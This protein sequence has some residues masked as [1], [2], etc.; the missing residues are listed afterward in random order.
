[1]NI[2]NTRSST[3]SGTVNVNANNKKYVLARSN[4]FYYLKFVNYNAE[5]F[6]TA[7][8]L[9][10]KPTVVFYTKNSA[11]KVI[12]D[13]SLANDT[14]KAY[15]GSFFA[16]FSVGAGFTLSN[17]EYLDKNDLSADVSSGATFDAF[18]DNKIFATV[19][20]VTRQ[21][22]A[23]DVYDANYFIEPPQISSG[24]TLGTSSS[25]ENYAL[26]SV[27]S[28]TSKPLSYLSP[29]VG[30]ILDVVNTSSAN[31]GIKFQITEITTLNNQEVF[32]VQK[33]FTGDLPVAESLVGQS[34]T[35]N[36]YVETT[37]NSNTVSD[38][39]NTDVGCCLDMVN[40]TFY[41]SST[42]YQCAL[43]T[44]NRYSFNTGLCDAS[45]S[46]LSTVSPTTTIN[47][48]SYPGEIFP[49]LLKDQIVTLP[50][51]VINNVF[52]VDSTAGI[53]FLSESSILLEKNK[54]YNFTQLHSSNTGYPLRLSVTPPNFT[55]IPI[56]Y[57]TKVYG[58]CLPQGVGSE[59][60]LV[61]DQSS[62]TTLY[63]F[64]ENNLQITGQTVF[65]GN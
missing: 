58:V 18:T 10:S 25:T 16:G 44:D 60:Y 54:I 11:N 63:M 47:D 49:F 17:G 42:R 45:I 59:L 51:K 12:Y 9:T 20:S 65:I 28:T 35:V 2:Q 53:T 5:L 57:I 1:M 38:V 36:L 19:T 41:S 33:V 55:T 3:Q 32:K 37:L 15:L 39:D 26:I 34:S 27:A 14:D 62:P 4:T 22:P 64:T 6:K 21:N 23:L 13:Y 56:P 52:T 24:N 7:S 29:K 48:I 43:R 40:N 50:V 46:N 61:T 31:N 8:N 30:D